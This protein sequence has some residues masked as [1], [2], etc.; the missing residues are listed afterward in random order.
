[1]TGTRMLA[2]HVHPEENVEVYTVLMFI[3]PTEHSYV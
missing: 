2:E 1:M 3:R